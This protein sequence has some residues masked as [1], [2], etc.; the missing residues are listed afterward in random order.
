MS[1]KE[2]LH[3]TLPHDVA[4]IIRDKVASGAYES[5]SDVIRDGLRALQARDAIVERWLRDEV[6]PTFD[7]VASGKEKLIPAEDVFS[8]L[9]SRYRARKTHK[10]A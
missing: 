5:E 4:Q 10:R 7:R 1:E 8:G 2:P 3:V 6:V 9:E